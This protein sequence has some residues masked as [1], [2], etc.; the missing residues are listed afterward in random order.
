MKQNK[1]ADG[2]EVLSS[3]LYEESYSLLRLLKI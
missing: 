1:H 3:N 2:I